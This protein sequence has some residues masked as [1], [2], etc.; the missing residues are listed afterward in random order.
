[1]VNSMQKHDAM[2]VGNARRL[3]QAIFER[4]VAGLRCSYFDIVPDKAQSEAVRIRIGK[5]LQ[6]RYR[7]EMSADGMLKDQ[8]GNN[9]CSQKN[10]Q[11]D[12]PAATEESCH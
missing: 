1:M 9:N 12:I 8:E 11:D 6:D 4:R 3:V 7:A 2:R 10:E 5:S